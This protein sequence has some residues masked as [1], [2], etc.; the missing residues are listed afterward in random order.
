MVLSAENHLQRLRSELQRTEV[1]LGQASKEQQRL[2]STDSGQQIIKENLIKKS[3]NV[4]Q[5]FC[6]SV[7]LPIHKQYLFS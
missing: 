6:L 7:S 1:D 2:R 4:T 3:K 5:I